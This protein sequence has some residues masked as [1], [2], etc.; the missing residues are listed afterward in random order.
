MTRFRL[1]IFVG[2]AAGYYLGTKAGRQRY[3]QINQAIANAREGRL[4]EKVFA[5]LDLSME[6][7][8]PETPLDM[9]EPSFN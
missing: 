1:G 8:R 6:R 2:F 7:F 3:E 9:R 5:A 4:F